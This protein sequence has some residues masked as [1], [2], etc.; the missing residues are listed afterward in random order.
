MAR[1]WCLILLSCLAACAGQSC[2]TASGVESASDS[3]CKEEHSI[4]EQQ[5]LLQTAGARLAKVQKT[6]AFS[7]GDND[8]EPYI[9][10]PVYDDDPEDEADGNESALLQADTGNS[11]WE[12]MYEGDASWEDDAYWEDSTFAEDSDT[13]SEIGEAVSDEDNSL[14][15]T[16]ADDSDWEDNTQSNDNLAPAGK[17][18]GKGKKGG[19]STE[20]K[21][22]KDG[23]M[24]ESTGEKKT[25]E[26]SDDE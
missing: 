23:A 12:E 15:E 20:K 5:A 17:G 1:L 19:L 8:T 10:D 21:A 14:L 7:A 22:A 24:V 26:D 16:S 9:G 13:W 6:A 25:F 2:Q 11:D 3:G 18:K 4:S